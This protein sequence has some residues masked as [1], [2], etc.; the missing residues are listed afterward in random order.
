[1]DFKETGQRGVKWIHLAQNRDK[2]Q[3]TLN[4]R[5]NLRVP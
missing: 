2:W 5:M 4:T 3:V 1:M